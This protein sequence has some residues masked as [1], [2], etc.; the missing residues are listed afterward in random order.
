MTKEIEADSTEK[1]KDQMLSSN[2]KDRESN[3]KEMVVFKQ[4]KNWEQEEVIEDI[5]PLAIEAG[6]ISD[7]VNKK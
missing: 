2:K 3:S 1:Q 7:I 6:N 5:V 4:Y